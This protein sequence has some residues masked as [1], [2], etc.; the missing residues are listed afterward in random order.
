[1]TEFKHHVLIIEDDDDWG[2]P[3]SDFLKRSVIQGHTTRFSL[4]K[5]G[6]KARSELRN[7]R[8][9]L[10]S[11]DLKLAELNDQKQ[12]IKIGL[13]LIEEAKR[14][15]C[16]RVILTGVPPEHA[17]QAYFYS[18]R[19]NIKVLIKAPGIGAPNEA[20]VVSAK[21][22]ASYVNNAF[23]PPHLINDIVPNDEANVSEHF[24]PMPELSYRK[25]YWQEAPYRLPFPLAKAAASL[26]QALRQPNLAEPIDSV[27]LANCQLFWRWTMML[28]WAQTAVLRQ[29]QLQLTQVQRSGLSDRD[30][31][32]KMIKEV[33]GLFEAVR[34]YCPSWASHLQEG[35]GLSDGL[36][37]TRLLRND[38]AHA[39]T[40]KALNHKDFWEKWDYPLLYLMDIAAFWSQFPLYLRPRREGAAWFAEPVRGLARPQD[41]ELISDLPADFVPIAEHV[42]QKVPV[43]SGGV[44][45][46]V[47]VDWFPY[48]RE[49]AD[50]SQTQY[51]LWL[52]QS[53]S[54]G[55]RW[56]MVNLMG[57]GEVKTV[58]VPHL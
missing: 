29:H 24:T 23:T 1:M 39:F 57:S 40:L 54:M 5:Y 22:W 25:A 26:I 17:N 30:D 13:E 18:G 53:R 51:N 56:H 35:K 3:M 28:C 49:Q 32:A 52:L 6:T 10:I 46:L 15:L 9:H 48:L 14:K 58:E 11:H 42:Y 12:D 50:S 4:A 27:L 20:Q 44:V 38:D 47:W 21:Q 34:T 7:T 31:A 43:V 8:Y 41:R 2:G 19:H 37:A 55:N 45:R 16:A 36:D 33:Q